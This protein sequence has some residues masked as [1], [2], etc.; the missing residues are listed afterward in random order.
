MVRR[1]LAAAA[2]CLLA[3]GC[4]NSRIVE[5]PITGWFKSSDKQT[6]A[7]QQP[8]G[9]SHCADIARE[10]RNEAN[11]E[12]EDEQVQKDTF[13]RTYAD[14]VAWIKVHSFSQ[15]EKASQ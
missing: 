12:G 15:P 10:R 11:F 1:F 7:A 3:A 8:Y 5:H 2:V 13:A 14:C 6:I 9:D 4:A